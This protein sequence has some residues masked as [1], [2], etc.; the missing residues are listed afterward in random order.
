MIQKINGIAVEVPARCNCLVWAYRR[1]YCRL[2]KVRGGRRRGGYI[3]KRRS[4]FS[5]AVRHVF[6]SRDLRRWWQYSA[7]SEVPRG[8]WWAVLWFE[9][10]LVLGD[11]A[12]K[13]TKFPSRTLRQNQ[14]VTKVMKAIYSAAILLPLLLASASAQDAARGTQVELFA[15][16]AGGQ[17]E[18]RK[19]EKAALEALSSGKVGMRING[20]DVVL[21]S[22]DHSLGH[23][24]A[25]PYDHRKDKTHPHVGGP[26]NDAPIRAIFVDKP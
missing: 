18:V 19:V 7:L 17:K 1:Y 21:Q 20:K 5:S 11:M 25:D 24:D 12:A 10:H 15:L 16:D 3:A 9:G 6:W 26:K 14:G 8:H 22:A 23:T 2:P 4:F 13:S